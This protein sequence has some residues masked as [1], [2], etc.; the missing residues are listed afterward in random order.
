MAVDTPINPRSH[1]YCNGLL[2]NL[3]TV[4]FTYLLSC[5]RHTQGAILSD[6]GQGLYTPALGGF[7]RCQG[8]QEQPEV[9][10]LHGSA[11]SVCIRSIV[12]NSSIYVLRV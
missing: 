2:Y 5:S 12:Q 4:I 3:R 1:A 11:S 6:D 10:Q 9:S 8:P 7:P